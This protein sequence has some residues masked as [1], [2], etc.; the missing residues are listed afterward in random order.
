MSNSI[1]VL[2]KTSLIAAAVVSLSACS[3]TSRTEGYDLSRVGNGILTAGRATADVS[4][5]VWNKTTYL[6]GFS[7]GDTDSRSDDVL[8]MDAEDMARLEDGSI[9]AR[10][11]TIRPIVIRSAIPNRPLQDETP[12]N[13]E[14]AENNQTSDF[15]TPIKRDSDNL[16]R[17][18]PDTTATV[19]Q[20]EST[21]IAED[22]VHKVAASETLWDIAKKTTGDANNWHVLADVNNLGPNAS[23]FPG[24]LLIIPADMIVPSSADDMASDTTVRQAPKQ[25]FVDTQDLTG[26]IKSQASAAA[27]QPQLEAST[28]VQAELS[29]TLE[30]E[31]V[32]GKAFTLKPGETLWDLAKRTT[33][34]ATNWKAIAGQNNFSAEQASFVRSGQT[35]YV[36]EDLVKPD[37]VESAINTATPDLN[38]TANSESSDVG[39]TL[40]AIQSAADTTQT[41]VDPAPVQS[42]ALRTMTISSASASAGASKKS[43]LLNG[44]SDP[45]TQSPSTIEAGQ[46]IKIVE[47]TFKSDEIAAPIS[48]AADAIKNV[49]KSTQQS[50][51]QIMVSGTYYPKAIYNNADFSSSLL[52]RVS[53]GTTLQVSKAM[54]NWYQVKTSKGLG[55]VH[56]RD[57]K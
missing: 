5:R 43:D 18:A 31:Q 23:V 4:E 21:L 52:M 50:P 14:L 32:G 1:P 35:I 49:G 44:N 53:P 25:I 10:D 2:F 11:T 20:T 3:T 36:P 48:Q 40:D 15:E 19:A 37:L 55:Y 51:E 46:P 47:A 34:D 42:D 30:P 41:A 16:A 38:T 57:I 29:D 33:G 12:T 17:T 26:A 27:A 8:L 39:P 28:T 56:Q 13:A 24:D 54:G 9:V 45:L 6:L 7:D 22:R